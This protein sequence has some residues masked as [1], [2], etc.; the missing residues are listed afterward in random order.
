MKL[1]SGEWRGWR[2]WV[3]RRDL[4]GGTVLHGVQSVINAQ[5]GKGA[6]SGRVFDSLHR[7]EVV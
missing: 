4:E 2:A 1:E 5:Q 7:N 6:A 3:E